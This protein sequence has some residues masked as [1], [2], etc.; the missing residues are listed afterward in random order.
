MD[1]ELLSQ[2]GAAPQEGS[3]KRR[4]IMDG[5][6]SVFLGSGFDGASMN[7]IARAA[8]V[9]KGTLYAYFESKEL[10][11]E[12]IIRAE[13]AQAAERLCIFKD[14]GDVRETLTDFGIRLIGR[15]SEPDTLAFARV[16]ISAAG[17]F[18][19]VGRAFYEA[20]PL[21]GAS[22]LSG[23]LAD[24]QN[25]GVLRVPDPE[26]AAWQFVDLCQSYV[27]KRLLFGVT[28]TVSPQEIRASVE[29]GVD[30]FL[31]AYGA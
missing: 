15:M 9:S 13:Y 30:V 6:R 22:R 5:A 12:A 26:R 18:P 8:G 23:R 28:A 3:A 24:M 11:F 27:Y 7:D 1:V 2:D 4:Q 17:K 14:T 21:Y 16:V 31:T 29:A 10:L 25:A 20:G 19:N